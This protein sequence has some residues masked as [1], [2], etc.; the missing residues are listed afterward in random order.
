LSTSTEFV[1]SEHLFV[2][3]DDQEFTAYYI[4]DPVVPEGVEGHE[5]VR[6]SKELFEQMM[7]GLGWRKVK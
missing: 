7:H 1:D 3:I 5:V 2:N 6:M 4:V